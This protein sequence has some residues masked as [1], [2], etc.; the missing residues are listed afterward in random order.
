MKLGTKEP[1]KL[2]G[3]GFAFRNLPVHETV[4]VCDEGKHIFFGTRFQ[5]FPDPTKEDQEEAVLVQKVYSEVLVEEILLFDMSNDFPHGEE[6]GNFGDGEEFGEGWFVSLARPTHDRLMATVAHSLAEMIVH[7]K[8]IDPDPGPVY[9][10]NGVGTQDYMELDSE[11]I[12]DRFSQIKFAFVDQEKAWEL[13]L[14]KIPKDLRQTVTAALYGR[15]VQDA[16]S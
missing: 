13:F 15:M 11:S 5:Y 12:S 4:S 6:F 2:E 10:I 14:T 8:Y 3:N 1:R 16:S 7:N 9:V